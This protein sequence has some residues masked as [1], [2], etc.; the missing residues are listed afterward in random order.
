MVTCTSTPGCLS[1]WNGPQV[2]ESVSRAVGG[3]ARI[4]STRPRIPSTPELI[5]LPVVLALIAMSAEPIAQAGWAV[6]P[7]GTTTC[8]SSFCGMASMNA[9]SSLERLPHATAQSS[10]NA[11]QAERI[12]HSQRELGV[13]EVLRLIDIVEEVVD[14]SAHDGGQPVGEVPREGGSEARRQGEEVLR[15]QL[16]VAGEI[17][18]QIDERD[19]GAQR[20]GHA[21]AQAEVAPERDAA[22]QLAEALGD[23]RDSGKLQIRR[24]ATER[25]VHAPRQVVTQVVARGQLDAGQRRRRKEAV[26]RCGIEEELTAA[27]AEQ[28]PARA[29]GALLRIVGERPPCQPRV[30]HLDWFLGDAEVAEQERVAV[31]LL[32]QI[33][34]GRKREPALVS[35]RLG[36]FGDGLG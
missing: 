4:A 3:T 33:T 24:P 35:A 32:H 31:A 27:G 19:A 7:C 6:S 36:D 22:A 13:A 5:A 29:G 8:S 14:P 34:A 18:R 2:R 23:G 20:D 12:V 21:V 1:S 30:G 16:R 9:T 25:E 15:R 11:L 26:T 28:A 17:A 10:N